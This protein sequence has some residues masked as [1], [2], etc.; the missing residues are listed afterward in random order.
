MVEDLWEVVG[1][2]REPADDDELEYKA[3]EKKNVKALYAIQNSCGP[4]M[5]HLISESETA[6]GAWEVL[7]NVS[8]LPGTQLSLCSKLQ[9][10][11]GVFLEYMHMLATLFPCA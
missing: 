1:A 4:E 5:Y 11:A 7:E 9:K 3:W 6:K 2:N 8:T 10:C